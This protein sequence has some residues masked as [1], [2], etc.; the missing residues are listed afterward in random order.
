M[1]QEQWWRD[2][3]ITITPRIEPIHTLRDAVISLHV[4]WLVQSKAKTLVQ[5]LDLSRP[6]LGVQNLEFWSWAG[7]NN[8]RSPKTDE[9]NNSVIICR[10]RIKTHDQSI[11]D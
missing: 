1:W 6:K 11:A 2:K 10:M 3:Y 9:V 4:F 7:A 8:P 5:R